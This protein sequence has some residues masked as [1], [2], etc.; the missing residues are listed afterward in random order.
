MVDEE[1][2]NPWLLVSEDAKSAYA[3]LLKQSN[4]KGK[5]VNQHGDECAM[6][7]PKTFS[8]NNPEVTFDKPDGFVIISRNFPCLSNNNDDVVANCTS[9]LT[10]AGLSP[11]DAGLRAKFQI[12]SYELKKTIRKKL[13]SKLKVHLNKAIFAETIKSGKEG[14]TACREAND[15]YKLFRNAP[16]TLSMFRQIYDSFI[17]PFEDGRLIDEAVYET[18]LECGIWYGIGP[19]Y[20]SLNNNVR[21]KTLKQSQLRAIGRDKVREFRHVFTEE[22]YS[23]HGVTFTLSKPGG[24]GKERRKQRQF[25]PSMVKGWCGSKHIAFCKDHNYNDPTPVLDGRQLEAKS[26]PFIPVRTES[27]FYNLSMMS[28]HLHCLI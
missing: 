13:S 5:V 1:V 26:A 14:S 4:G 17:K 15:V 8:G 21:K 23:K 2:A 10:A 27:F 12:L 28:S 22:K 25:D 9:E 16:P 18:M 11:A 24:R 3:L 6:V 19:A 20:S 7:A